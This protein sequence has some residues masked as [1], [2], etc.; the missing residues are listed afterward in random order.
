MLIWNEIPGSHYVVYTS[1]VDDFTHF[2]TITVP[3]GENVAGPYTLN[4]RHVSNEAFVANYG[5]LA[6]AKEAAEQAS[7]AFG[8]LPETEPK[9]IVVKGWVG[10]FVERGRK[11]IVG[12]SSGEELENWFYRTRSFGW[13]DAKWT[14]AEARVSVKG[15]YDERKRQE[16]ET[17]AARCRKAGCR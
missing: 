8:W 7:I 12:L 15:F 6:E 14:R 9:E 2:W 17:S 16:K 5:S 10:T 13:V 1:M 4:L 3:V 11:K